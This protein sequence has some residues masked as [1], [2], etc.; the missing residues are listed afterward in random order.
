MTGTFA[1]ADEPTRA[2]AVL[3]APGRGE[4]GPRKEELPVRRALDARFR[5]RLEAAR[6]R[7]EPLGYDRF[8][9]GGGVACS[10]SRSRGFLRISC[11]ALSRD[12]CAI[13]M[14]FVASA[15]RLL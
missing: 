15:P 11:L 3:A 14:P 9:G 13:F 2:A 10:L 4:Q 8:V 1:T 6:A 12:S 7:S 5:A